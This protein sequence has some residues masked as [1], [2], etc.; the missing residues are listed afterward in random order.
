M[1]PSFGCHVMAK[2]TGS[3]CNIDCE[4]C[5]YQEKDKLYPERQSDWRMPDDT[6][7]AY[8]KQHI[9]AQPG[10]EV[11]ITWQG[12]EPTLMGLDFFQRA[13][14]LC[15]KYANGKQITHAFQ[16]NGILLNDKW[17]EFF[18]QHN[19]LIGVSIDGPEDL[20]D[21][22]RQTR[23]GKGTHQ[24]VLAAIELLKK[25]QVEFNTLTVINALNVKHP[26]RVYQFL[27]S[28]GS[29]FLQFIPL[30]ERD[31]AQQDNPIQNLAS[32]GE[33]FG[34][35]TKWSVDPEEYGQFLTT[36]FD[37]WVRNDIGRT[38]VQM[39]DTTLASW[40][41]QPPGICIFSKQCGH[42]FALEANGDL[43][44]CDHYVYPEYK[45]G[46]LHET[47]ISEMNH[48]EEAIKFGKDKFDSLNDKCRQC[49][50]LPAC[51]GGCPKHRFERGP[52]GKIDHNYLCAG[53][54]KYFKH[55]DEAMSIM[56]RL[57]QNRRP[58]SDIK[59]FLAEQPA[60]SKVVGRNDP[61]PCGSGKKY[62]KCCD[63]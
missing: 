2:P 48:S 57:L 30:V 8:I 39:F 15:D 33:A 21:H 59:Y 43:Y 42:A 60:P 50:Y 49:R 22:Y 12:G 26:L 61:C 36:L 28:T 55:V 4:Y 45:L 20:H 25:H 9:E 58:A 47:T 23:S 56:A 41:G 10:H 19:F 51:H 38:F 18:K 16:T 54:F 7:D 34:K 52:S 46:N 1:Q 31:T 44:Q 40:L 13:V 53:Y 6:L 11:Q 63:K 24:K 27:K 14:E 17:C 32:P 37:Y 62:K 29:T 3:V 5:F 35:V